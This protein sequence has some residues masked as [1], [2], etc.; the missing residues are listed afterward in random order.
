[1]TNEVTAT[2]VEKSDIPVY[3]HEDLEKAKQEVAKQSFQSGYGKARQELTQPVA[4]PMDVNQ[5]AYAPQANAMQQPVQP[6]MQQA[7]SISPE[8]Q[9]A[10]NQAAAQ[11]YA[12]M[13]Q[14]AYQEQQEALARQT[15]QELTAKIQAAQPKYSDYNEVVGGAQFDKSPEI[16]GY[17][18]SVPNAG[19]ILYH[20]AKHPEKAGAIMALKDN[21]NLA[22]AAM[23]R[24][25]DSLQTNEAAQHVPQ[26]NEPLD[27]LTPSSVGVA[28]K[29]NLRDLKARYRK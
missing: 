11:H 4:Q 7:Q 25:S 22:F 13:Q 26:A 1:M 27:Q 2:P 23:K 10:A 16:L 28:G 6:Q 29:P 19:D 18:N 20:L 5:G 9:Q 14:K 8:M 17:A 3:T 21:P 15:G 12:A 24:L